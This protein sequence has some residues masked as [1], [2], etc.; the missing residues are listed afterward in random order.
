MFSLVKV[1]ANAINPSV[2]SNFIL[3][4]IITGYFYVEPKNPI[5]IG[6]EPQT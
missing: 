2:N 4:S 5:K 6:L 3:P 1:K